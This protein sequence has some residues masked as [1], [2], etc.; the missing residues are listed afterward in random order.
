MP[1]DPQMKKI[2]GQFNKYFG[3]VTV[4]ENILTDATSPDV[5]KAKASIVEGTRAEDYR[6]EATKAEATRD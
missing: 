5:T 2:C 6:T 4:A 3:L 1:L